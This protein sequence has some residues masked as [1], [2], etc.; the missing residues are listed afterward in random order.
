MTGSFSLSIILFLS[1][2]VAVD[3]MNH[4]LTPLR[5]WTADISIISPAQ[6]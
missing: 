5:P 4:S 2:S 3:F 1:F 6:P